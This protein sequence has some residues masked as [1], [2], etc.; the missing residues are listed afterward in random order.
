MIEVQQ[1]RIYFMHRG[2]ILVQI[3][4]ESFFANE[5]I[6]TA[7]KQNEKGHEQCSLSMQF[8]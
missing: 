7:N 2:R 8:I 3:E 5:V 6:N 1:I 4:R